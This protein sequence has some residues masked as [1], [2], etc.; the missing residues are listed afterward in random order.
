ML[1][2][3]ARTGKS[4]IQ[5][6]TAHTMSWH[7]TGYKLS[8]VNQKE[9]QLLFSFQVLLCFKAAASGLQEQ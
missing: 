5:P 4:V 6:V 3:R 2:L 7:T 9:L 8:F 1:N